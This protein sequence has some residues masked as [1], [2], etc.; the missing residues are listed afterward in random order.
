MLIRWGVLRV[1]VMLLVIAGVSHA[2]GR[3]GRKEGERRYV[4]ANAHYEAG[5]YA[6]AIVELRA[7]YAAD[8]QGQY[9]FAIAQAHRMADECET[10]IE[11]FGAFLRTGPK[12]NATKAAQRYID[13]CRA[14]LAAKR[15]AAQAAAASQTPA[16]APQPAPPPP[17]SE[18]LVVREVER[19]YTREVYIPWYGDWQGDTLAAAGVVTL[20]TGVTFLV[21]AN[22]HDDDATHATSYDAL[23]RSLTLRD[24]DQVVGGIAIATGSALAVAA[25]ARYALRPKRVQTE[26]FVQPAQ[27]GASVGVTGRW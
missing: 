13:D 14:T 18:P 23:D 9:L 11:A 25:L 21:I 27:S 2:G 8:A 16:P 19:V 5:R 22:G 7:A 12:P 1:L 15:A 20:L 17:P 4:A 6:E 3:S 10:A 24:R 26:V